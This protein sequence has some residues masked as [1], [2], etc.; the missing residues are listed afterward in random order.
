MRRLIGIA[1]LGVVA[2]ALLL[3][4]GRSLDAPAH[5]ASP[6]A[7]EPPELA[8]LK[9]VNAWGPPKDPQLLFL[10][11]AQFA[12]AGRHAEGIAYFEQALQRFGPEL[13]DVQRGLYLT[14]LASLRAGFAQQVFVLKRVGWV[15]D[16]VQQLDE[17]KRLTGNNVF[18]VRWMS[19]FVRA[20]LPG[21]FDERERAIDDLRWCEAHADKAPHAGWLREVYA[22][23]V[24]LARDAGDEKTAATYQA[25]AGT[26]S[27]NRPAVFN[28]P[29]SEDAT[30][31]HTFSPR[32]VREV[33]PGTVYVLSGFEFTEYSFVVSADKRELVA[34]DAG[35]RPD[36]AQAALAALRA[37]VPA[38]PPLT[39]V[40]VT[41]AHWD[42]VG[43][44]RAFRSSR[45]RRVSSA[46]PITG[47]NSPTT[48]PRTRRR[49]S[50][51]SARTS[52]SPTCWRIAPTFLSTDRRNS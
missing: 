47:K 51:S 36:A 29:F 26:A 5:A 42:H 41:H 3:A 31:G 9:Q 50:G 7:G 46:V 39:T 35:T 22:T 25:L 16:T 2:A 44:A 52:T 8:Y 30:R 43:G 33:V 32:A 38:L 13:N 20:Q 21:F 17:A 6:A 40:L 37:Q 24:R 1:I 15:R 48:R 27:D 12:N 10:L 4:L 23:R 45:R 34:I 11:M 18:V 14:A 49:C 28:T 19:G